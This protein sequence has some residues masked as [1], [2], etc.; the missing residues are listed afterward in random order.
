MIIEHAALRVTAGREEEFEATMRTALAIIE[1]A[2]DCFGAQIR[3]QAEDG[4]VFLLIVNWSSV[5]AH[6]AFRETA[7][8]E[9]WRTLTHHFYSERPVVTHFHEPLS[10]YEGS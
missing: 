9:Q 8:F 5:E 7:L 10:R 3:R 6:M 1:S 4:A 2:P